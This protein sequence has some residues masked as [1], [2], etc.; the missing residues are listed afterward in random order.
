[1]KGLVASFLIAMAA[2]PV[3]SAA[4]EAGYVGGS[5]CA[6]C[7]AP[8]WQAWQGSHH[9]L[10]MAIP[11]ETTVL[12]DFDDRAF[13]AHGVTST[14]YRK[15]GEY[16]VRT[17]GADG[18]LAHYPVRYTFGWY[19]L[20]QYLIDVGMGRLQALGIAWDSRPAGEGGQRWF[21]LYPNEPVDHRH[22]LHWTGREQNWNYQCA[23]CHSTELQKG[24]D[25]VEDSYQTTY[26]EI[27]VACEACHG[28]GRLHVEWATALDGPGR[29]ANSD[30]GLSVRFASLDPASW[31]TDQTTGL[32]VRS[33][34]IDRTEVETC[35]LCHARRGEFWDDYQQGEPLAQ[36]HRLALLEDGLYF[37]DGQI[38]DEV[39]VYGSFIQ[40]K[41]YRAGVTCS[42]CHD[43]HSLELRQT[44]NAVC[45]QCHVA[46]RYDDASH[47]HHPESAEAVACTACHMPQRVYMVNDW[48][49]DHSFR[50]PRPD[51]SATLGTPNA[52]NGCHV[53]QTAA[54]AADTVSQWFPDSPH[55]GE[56]FGQTFHAAAS[57]D[58]AVAA[59][60]LSLAGDV[61]NADIVRAT[62]LDRLRAFAQSEHLLTVRRLLADSSPLVRAAAVRFL[63]VTDISTQV[64]LAWLLL[65]DP[66][67]LVRLDAARLLAPLLGQQVPARY[68]ETLT[69]AVEEYAQ[70]LAVTAERPE[71]QLSLGL[72]AV[73]LGEY[74]R[75]EA[76]YRQAMR[77][78]PDFAPGYANLAD[79]YRGM[80]RDE[81][82]EAVLRA[83]I[84]ALPDD[85]SLA[86]ALGL[87][88][89][90][91]KRLPEALGYLEIASAKAPENARFSLVYAVA[92]ESVGEV[93]KALA[94]LR[95]AQARH[96]YRTDIAQ[97][98]EQMARR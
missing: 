3:A 30:L 75:A 56:H 45:T 60:L 76:A 54:W 49:A 4:D 46:D 79:L 15:D 73:S 86:H 8:E 29:D 96:P 85:A 83:G 11:D 81:Q 88:L 69:K 72:L 53:D 84:E 31:T 42:N 5:R 39:Y 77:L 25:P 14:F 32:P 80:G 26:A 13:S 87:L 70:S 7:H 44:G 41:M 92:L 23:E 52:C 37:P 48:R 27:D 36:T 74:E 94:V 12:G 62:A 67:R 33:H 57:G 47:H 38:R 65:N 97:T 28:P 51:L 63:E 91:E 18:V 35:A 24:Y 89:V 2:L 95:A 71:S 58:P 66:V 10:A 21:H 1:M 90:R 50:V 9:D 68:R 22:P 20:Q 17:D 19:P 93:D 43:P 40:S 98:I 59:P 61:R 16:M 78:A 34:S 55:R 6:E 82:G 64:D